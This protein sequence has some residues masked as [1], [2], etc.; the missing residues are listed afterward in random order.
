MATPVIAANGDAWNEGR[1][2]KAIQAGDGTLNTK[3]W[4]GRVRYTGSAWEVH[5]TTFSAGITS[6]GIAWSTDHINITI[7]GMTQ[8]SLVIASPVLADGNYWVKAYAASA[9]QVQVAF[10]NDAGARQ[11]TQGTAMDCELVVWGN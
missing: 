4:G 2:Q 10:Y 1:A 8:A 6:G 11:T 9:S 5:A 7:S 3:M